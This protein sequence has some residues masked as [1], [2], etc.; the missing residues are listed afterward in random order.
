VFTVKD[1]T[2][3]VTTYKGGAFLDATMNSLRYWYPKLDVII[4]AGGDY[5][6][7]CPETKGED[8]I[9]MSDW[10]IEDCRNAAAQ[11]AETKLLLFMDDD[12]KVLG[13]GAIEQLV[14]VMNIPGGA[15]CPRP[16]AQTGAYGL[17][18]LNWERRVGV[19][20]TEFTRHIE[21]T[22]SPAYFS[23]HRRDAYFEVGGMPKHEEFYPAPLRIRNALASK[24]PGYCGDFVISKRYRESGWMVVTPKARVPVLHWAGRYR[25]NRPDH[26]RIVEDWWYANTVHVRV[27]PLDEYEKKWRACAFQQGLGARIKGL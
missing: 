10:P 23:M 2:A 20:G 22:A 19:V 12:V 11:L 15:D 1:V 26:P 7:L 21:I 6:D 24:L 9:I 17:K 25:V 3:I 16:I 4:A 13:A 5:V 8:V 18:V 27:N 14:E